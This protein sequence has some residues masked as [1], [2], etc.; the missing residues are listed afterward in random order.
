MIFRWPT[1]H[2]SLKKSPLTPDTASPLEMFENLLGE[3]I[4][5]ILGENID[6]LIVAMMESS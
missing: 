3:G 2:H 1:D 6:S 5:I 4:Y